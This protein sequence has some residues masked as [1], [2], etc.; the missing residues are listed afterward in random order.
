MLRYALECSMREG[1]ENADEEVAMRTEA[2]RTERSKHEMP[3]IHVGLKE[4]LQ[5]GHTLPATWYTDPAVFE[6]E[7][8]RIFRHS[9]QFVGFSE[10][11][12]ERGSFFTTRVSGIP[13]VLTRDQE[14]QIHAFVNVCRHRGSELVLA[15]NGCH[16][17]LQC[18]YHAWTYN[19]DGS[20]RSAPGAKDEPDFNPGHYSL[21][22]LPIGVWGPLIFVHLD[23]LATEPLEVTLG[24]LPQLTAASGVQFDG[25]RRRVRH[26]YDIAANWKVIVDNYLECYHCPVAHKSFSSLIDLN[27]YTV[28]EYEWFSVQGGAL[29]APSRANS[30]PEPYAVQGAVQAGFYAFLWP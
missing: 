30:Q 22:S 3:P 7:Q 17:T 28:A 20:L 16:Q 27:K 13:L 6:A 23:S 25:I 29:K 9:W 18:H 8:A 15:E 12:P 2:M 19:L 26:T 24:E 4:S 14:G 10:H 11:L 5:Q 21:I 1:R